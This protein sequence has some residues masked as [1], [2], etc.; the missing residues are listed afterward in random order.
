VLAVEL[1]NQA[2]TARLLP[3]FT[4]CDLGVESDAVSSALDV[5]D[6]IGAG[7]GALNGATAVTGAVVLKDPGLCV[8]LGRDELVACVVVATIG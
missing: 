1:D 2:G 4:R 7:L 6:A 8:V 5:V 3:P